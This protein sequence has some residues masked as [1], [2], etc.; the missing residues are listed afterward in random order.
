MA[1]Y[2]NKMQVFKIDQ[3][4]AAVLYTDPVLDLDKIQ[5]S[6]WTGT[7]KKGMTFDLNQ[8]ANNP[9][10]AQ[11]LNDFGKEATDT[12]EE[13]TLID[14]TKEAVATTLPE[15]LAVIP[16]NTALDADTPPAMRRQI[17]VACI[18][19]GDGAGDVS[20]EYNKFARRKTIFKTVKWNYT[21]P[22]LLPGDIFDV[23]LGIDTTDTTPLTAGSLCFCPTQINPDMHGIEG[24]VLLTP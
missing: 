17:I 14:G 19:L 6:N 2:V 22:L 23:A 11:F 24:W 18:D 5:V 4:T 15:L 20:Y 9:V 12:P 13:V 10:V 21:N 8:L 3:A 1:G 16:G 7:V